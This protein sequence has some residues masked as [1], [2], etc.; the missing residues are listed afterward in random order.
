MCSSGAFCRFPD[1][2]DHRRIL[3][4]GREL[5]IPLEVLIYP[6]WTLGAV[7]D[8]IARFSLDIRAIH[9][10][11]DI[12]ARLAAG[13]SLGF[14]LLERNVEFAVRLG[15]GLVV[16]HAWRAD[17]AG[18]ARCLEALPRCASIAAG[19]GVV[20]GLETVPC[21]SLPILPTVREAISRA[22]SCGVVLDTEFLARAGELDAALA[23]SWLWEGD[24]VIHVHAKDWSGSFDL[25]EG[26]R[27]LQPGDG[28][29]DFPRLGRAL[30]ESG[31]GGGLSLEASALD[32]AGHVDLDALRRSI[33]YLDSL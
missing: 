8:D 4:Y 31:F 13:D 14:G 11:K 32:A 12:T 24:R 10:D 21:G 26:P 3:S 30:T 22:G 19:G 5:G 20:L 16:L 17:G 6:N 28:L 29:V 23:S 25:D 18:V 27:Y 1:L 9:A 7:A 2:T 15:A 33:E